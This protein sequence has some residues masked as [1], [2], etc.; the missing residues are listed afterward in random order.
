[1]VNDGLIVF[2]ALVLT[3]TNLETEE[4]DALTD[5]DVKTSDGR[6]RGSRCF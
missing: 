2:V 3:E 4:N 1:M 6:A 5:G